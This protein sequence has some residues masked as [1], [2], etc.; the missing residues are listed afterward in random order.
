MAPTLDTLQP[1]D[2]IVYAECKSLARLR[3]I[4][5]GRPAPQIAAA[6]AAWRAA[7]AGRVSLLQRRTGDGM[8]QY[9]A[10]GRTAIDRHPVQ[11]HYQEVARRAA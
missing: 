10:V 9:L 6:E 2:V 3:E 8:I 7:L 11:P 1:G 4:T 5:K